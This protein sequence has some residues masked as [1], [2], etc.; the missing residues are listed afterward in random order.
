MSSVVIDCSV[1]AK[2]FVGGH[3]WEKALS[4]LKS[5][6]TET[7]TL[8]APDFIQVELANVLWKL[9][10]GGH[11]KLQFAQEALNEFSTIEITYTVATELL[12]DAFALAVKHKRSVYDSLYIALSVRAGCPMITAD[13]RLY[14]SIKENFTNMVLLENWT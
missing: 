5:H 8:L 1:A 9:Q 4:I 3:H 12:A 2:W 11:L 7:L 10:R 14:N 6:R 13:E